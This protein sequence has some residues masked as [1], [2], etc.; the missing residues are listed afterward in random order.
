MTDA[1]EVLIDNLV[2]KYAPGADWSMVG[3]AIHIEG[4]SALAVRTIAWRVKA[5]GW[6]V[7]VEGVG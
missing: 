6:S 2:A 7:A 5:H 4:A 3:D 1:L